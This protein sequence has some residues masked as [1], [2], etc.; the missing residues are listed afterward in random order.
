[1]SKRGRPYKSEMNYCPDC[2][3]VW[4]IIKASN[5]GSTGKLVYYPD[6]PTIGKPRVICP[7]CK[8]KLDET[9]N[10]QQIER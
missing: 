7:E 5:Y 10:Y 2:L 9:L 8:V 6:F 4:E 1:M 3:R